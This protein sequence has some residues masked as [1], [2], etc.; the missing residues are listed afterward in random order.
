MTRV[1]RTR[2]RVPPSAISIRQPCRRWPSSATR[3]SSVAGQGWRMV[4]SPRYFEGTELEETF[5]LVTWPAPG[6]QT[7][8]V[9]I[10]DPTDP[11]LPEFCRLLDDARVRY[12]GIG[13][14]APQIGVGVRIATS[15]IA[16]GDRLGYGVYPDT[17]YTVLINPR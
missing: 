10:A 11:R 14:A 2:W 13:I 7:P 6:L 3:E 9:D 1:P 8:S 17:D 16:A 4:D 12:L 5:E 15:R